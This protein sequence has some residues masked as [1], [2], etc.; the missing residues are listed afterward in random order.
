MS[1]AYQRLVQFLDSEMQMQ[2]IYQPLMLDVLLT[3]GGTASSRDI[4]AAFLAHDESQIDY[5][6]EIV[7]NM[8]G[9]VLRKRG[10]VRREG[11]GYALDIDLSEISD[12]ERADVIRRCQVAVE[13]Y[14]ARRG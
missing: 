5:Y 6:E 10:I 12:E 11:K 1:L 7:H 8:P 9:R 13:A 4:A 2:H 14:K 3:H